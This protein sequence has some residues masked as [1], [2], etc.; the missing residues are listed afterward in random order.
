MMKNLR[1]MLLVSLLLTFN[2]VFTQTFKAV[3]NIAGLT[4]FSKNN[5][6]SVADYDGDGDLDF[7]VVAVAKDEE[8]NSLTHSRLYRNNND[9]TFTDVTEASGLT[10]LLPSGGVI[11]ELDEFKALEGFKYGAFWGDYDNDGYPDILFTHRKKFQLFH[12]QGDGSFVEVTSQLGSQSENEC[13]NTSAVWFDYNNDSFLDIFIPTWKSCSFNFLYKNNGDGTFTNTSELINVGGNDNLPSFNPYPFDFNNDGYMDLY[14]SN[15]LRKTNQLFI[16]KAGEAFEEDAASYGLD[17]KVDDM[18]VAIS[19]YNNDGHFDIFITAIQQNVLLTNN[20]DNTF[21]DKAFEHTVLQTGWAWGTTFADFDLDGDEDLFIANGYEFGTWGADTNVYYENKYANGENE[22]TLQESSGLEDFGISVSVVDFDYDNDGDL[23]ILVTNSNK[24]S[25]LYENETINNIEGSNLQWLKVS[26][27]GTVSNRDAIGT[28]LE[29][30]TN[31]SI[32]KRYYNGVGFLGQNLKPVH[33]GLKEGETINSLKIKWPSGIEETHMNINSNTYIKAIE[34]SGFEVLNNT[35]STKT[36]GCT[37]PNSCNYNENALID[38]GSCEYLPFSNI[39]E[40]AGNTGNFKTETYYLAL[41]PDQTVVWQVEGGKILSGQNSDTI[42]VEWGFE[43]TGNLS[44]LVSDSL[45]FSEE[46]ALTVN[47]SVSEV[48]KDKSIARIWN[49]ALLDAIRRD[50]ARPTVHARNLF[51][52]SAAM[53]D[54]WAIYHK[55]KPYLIGNEVHGFNSQFSEFKVNQENFDDDLRKVISYTAYRILSYRFKNSPNKENTL[56]KFDLLMD[57]LGFDSNVVRTDYQNGDPAALGNFIAENYIQYGHIDGS[58]E[59]TSYDNA[60]YQPINSP[61]VPVLPGNPTITDPNRW[62]SLSLDTF[63]DQSG[64]LIEGSTIDFLSPEWGNVSPFAMNNNVVTNFNREGNN[65]K[66]YNDPAPPPY[67]NGDNQQ[68]SEAYKWGFSLVSIWSSH[69]NPND[70]VMWDIS[71]KS[72]GNVEIENFPTNYTDHPNF[73]KLLE[74]GDIGQG[75]AVNPITGSAY[76]T[77]MIPRG[78]YTRV[79]AEFWA[80][81]PDSETPPGHWFSILNYVSD[82]PSLEKRYNGNGPLLSE[83]EWDIKTYYILGGAM[84]DAAISAW[85]IKG[86]YD[87]IRPISAIRYMA[88]KGQSTDSNLPNYNEDGIPLIEGYIEIVDEDDPLVG[89]ENK[90]LGKIKLYAWKGHKYIGDTESDT[91]GVDWILSEDWWPYQRP[92]FVT[93]PFAGYVSG[94][95]T[96][97]RA[98]AEVM[99]LMTGSAY[100]PDGMGE[101]VAKKNEFLVFEEGPSVDVTLQWATYRDAS[102]QCSLSRLWGGIHPPA[103]DIAGRVI[104]EKIGIDAFNFATSYF[105]NNPYQDASVGNA[106]YPNPNSSGIIYISNT[107]STDTFR[108]FDLKGSQIK[109]ENVQFED[110]NQSSRLKLSNNLSSGL[111][112]L[113]VNNSDAKRII[114]DFY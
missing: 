108:L 58:R 40:G 84:H 103:D 64:N 57:Q 67:L 110:N 39:I 15:D 88:D 3:E 98:A 19:D 86:W 37:D 31:Q 56:A 63:I 93:P 54:A 91:A 72:I 45:C 97:S 99:T 2:S 104:G 65:Y 18:G 94:H 25:R 1:G 73:Y 35:P 105:E 111:Y 22:F 21:T 80:D 66:V 50:Y 77:Q 107:K 43:S 61:L 44:A 46:I 106:I 13:E 12:N 47:L 29:L 109:I 60:Y 112:L 90:N 95:S 71:P 85:S 82:H 8:N 76:E 38:D 102:D 62:Q 23:D 6:A 70:G 17:T 87:Y 14:L 5:G 69:L 24:R 10:N 113:K 48:P 101:F 41:Q 100:F 27:Q 42:T 26:L 75:H 89:R 92:S 51:H 33:F 81:G 83:L 20:G 74:G 28:I 96:Y 59:Q 36:Y 79:L 16:N 7:F 114:V 34:N 55:T 9:G 32:L 4:D 52:T 49:E 53:Y 30:T 11:E 68:S 78:D